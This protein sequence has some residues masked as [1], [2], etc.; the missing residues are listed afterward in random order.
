MYILEVNNI[1]SE[2]Q[3]EFKTKR[4]DMLLEFCKQELAEFYDKQDSIIEYRDKDYYKKM[5]KYNRR[6][7]SFG[8]LNQ[9]TL[10]LINIT[11]KETFDTIINCID[12]FFSDIHNELNNTNCDCEDCNNSNINNVIR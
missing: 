5:L 11:S 7:I 12:K 8:I 6:F 9:Y 1:T 10:R 2:Y 3:I 4:L